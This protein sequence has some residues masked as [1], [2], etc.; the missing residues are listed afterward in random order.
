MNLFHGQIQETTNE[1]LMVYTKASTFLNMPRFIDL[2]ECLVK[3]HFKRVVYSQENNS[4]AT[5]FISN[6]TNPI[7]QSSFVYKEKTRRQA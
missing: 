2:S 3:Y 4:N 5:R 7:N 1:F 6:D